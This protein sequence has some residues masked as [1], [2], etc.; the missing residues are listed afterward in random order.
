[1]QW[2]STGAAGG[3]TISGYSGGRRSPIGIG[4]AVAVHAL[5]IG[6]YL[7]M[8][9]EVID[10]FH[11]SPFT[12]YAV[13]ETP[14]P[15]PEKAAPE[16]DSKIPPKDRSQPT[17][18]SDPIVD[19]VIKG[20]FTAKTDDHPTGDS[21]T[22]T[23]VQPIIPPLP[24]PVLAE[25]SID[26]RALAAFQPDYPGAMIRQGMEGKVV[27][28]VTIGPDGRVIDI[29]RLSAADEAFWIATQRHALRKWRFRPATRDGVPVSSTKVLTVHFRL[30][31]V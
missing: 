25:A 13:P 17:T 1:M 10:T 7:L 20:G 27:V 15:P 4:G 22:G 30:A 24:E 29:E 21:G 9:K 31:D 16:T 23:I 28:R 26:P 12:T 6:A 8:P 14:P 2:I 3:E 18:V 11:S 19:T 5:V